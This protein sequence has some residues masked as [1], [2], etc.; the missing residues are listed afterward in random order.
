[1]RVPSGSLMSIVGPPDTD[2]T[3]INHDT[4]NDER[5]FTALPLVDGLSAS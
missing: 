1:M 5:F 2:D 4:N 3:T